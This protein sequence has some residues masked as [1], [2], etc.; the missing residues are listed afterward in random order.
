[1]ILHVYTHYNIKTVEELDTIVQMAYYNDI[2]H[3]KFVCC[4][5]YSQS[6]PVMVKFTDGYMCHY[7]RLTS[8]EHINCIISVHAMNANI[9]A[10]VIHQKSAKT[11]STRGGV[12]I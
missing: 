4:A 10:V 2:L 6:E 5:P 9:C 12:A 3:V 11:F 8:D 7:E 1:M